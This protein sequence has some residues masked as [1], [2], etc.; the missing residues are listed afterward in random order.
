MIN[1]QKCNEVPKD[2]HIDF[3]Q[4]LL[5]QLTPFPPRFYNENDFHSVLKFRTAPPNNHIE[6][7][8]KVFHSQ[9]SRWKIVIEFSI[10][11]GLYITG[12]RYRSCGKGSQIFSCCII[13]IQGEKHWRSR[14]NITTRKFGRRER[15]V[16]KRRVGNSEVLQPLKITCLPSHRQNTRTRGSLFYMKDFSPPHIKSGFTSNVVS[17]LQ[18]TRAKLVTH[19]TLVSIKCTVTPLT[20]LPWSRHFLCTPS[21]VQGCE[22]STVQSPTRKLKDNVFLL[23]YTP[24][25]MVYHLHV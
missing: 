24:S 4:D 9:V 12:R 22:S 17:I 10:S 13:Y 1:W 8:Q 15:R 23:N 3:T 18:L 11:R 25:T 19:F 2:N 20:A 14:K 5:H 7:I 6:L 16:G 21:P